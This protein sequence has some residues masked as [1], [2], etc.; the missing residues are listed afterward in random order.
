[1]VPNAMTVCNFIIFEYT[2][3][4]GEV[5]VNN[6]NVESPDFRKLMEVVHAMDSC[7]GTLWW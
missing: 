6:L 5:Y 2:T 7:V 3:A 4:F 1:M